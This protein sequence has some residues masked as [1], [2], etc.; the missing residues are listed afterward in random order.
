MQQDHVGGTHPTCPL[1]DGVNQDCDGADAPEP[2]GAGDPAGVDIR[3]AVSTRVMCAARCAGILSGLVV[4]SC[5]A[6]QPAPETFGEPSRTDVA[7]ALVARAPTL[8][9]TLRDPTPQ[10]G[11]S[12]GAGIAW[13]QDGGTL[14]VGVPTAEVEGCPDDLSSGGRCRDAG[15]VV[16]FRR[17]ESGWTVSAVLGLENPEAY[18]WLGASVAVS[19]DGTVV[20]VAGASG[21]GVV[22]IY[23]SATAGWVLE[24]RLSGTDRF[25]HF[26][27]TVALS[28]AGDRLAVAAPGEDGSGRGVN[29]EVDN[30]AEDDGAAYV[31]RHEGTDWRLEATLK[32]SEPVGPLTHSSFGQTLAW[33]RDASVL[34]VGALQ[35]RRAEVF[36]REGVVWSTDAVLQSPNEQGSALGRAVA[37][38]ADGRTAAVGDPGAGQVHLFRRETSGWLPSRTFTGEPGGQFGEAVALDAGG[39]R[40]LVGAPDDSE[41]QLFRTSEEAP[42]ATVTS[43]TSAIDAPYS[44]WFGGNIALA[45]GIGFVVTADRRKGF[46]EASTAEESCGS[47]Y[48]Y[49]W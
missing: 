14:A 26:G 21:A 44:D 41:V 9:A 19:A 40:L 29:P 2:S 8:A 11:D 4:V 18:R 12:F 45:E 22:D 15:H 3:V 35:K 33:N 27:A 36:R 37:V 30:A 16:V 48:T 5:A 10:S 1:W 43:G 31:Y 28:S 47:V 6:R 39:D 7:P 25:D 34:V 13:S 20:A 38:S 49:S 17:G 23:R 24:R 46:R 32:G 42:Y